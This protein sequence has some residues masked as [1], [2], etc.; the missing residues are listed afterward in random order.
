LSTELCAKELHL[1]ERALS[2]PEAM[3]RND[4]YQ[5]VNVAAS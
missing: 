2:Y 3:I 1:P 4:S 5:G